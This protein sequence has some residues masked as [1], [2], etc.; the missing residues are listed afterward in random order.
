MVYSYNEKKCITA[1][2]IGNKAYNLF[3]LNDCTKSVPPWICL[4]NQFMDSLFKTEQGKSTY[5]YINMYMIN[6]I[7]LHDKLKVIRDKIKSLP[8]PENVYGLIIEKIKMAKLKPPYAVRSS[9][10]LEDNTKRSGAGIYDTILDVKHECL[11]DAILECI[12]SLFNEKAF[13]Y[14]GNRN[15]SMSE[16]KIAVIIQEMV[17][18]KKS[19]IIFTCNPVNSNY[20]EMIL[21]IGEG[22]GSGIVSG[23]K[24]VGTYLY[25]KVTKQMSIIEP[26]ET[27]LEHEEVEALKAFAYAIEKS[28]GIHQDIEWAID[29]DERVWLLQSRPVTTVYK[30]QSVLREPIIFLIQ[31][32]TDKNKEHL[33]HLK[34]R[35]NRWVK[36]KIPFSRA[37]ATANAPMSKWYFIKYNMHIITPKICD[38]ILNDIYS[39]YLFI[40][41]NDNVI[42]ITIRSVDLYKKLKELAE[43]F[44]GEDLTVAIKEAYPNDASILASLTD[45]GNIY[46]EYMPGALKWI[47][48]GVLQP[49]NMLISLEGNIL[50]QTEK[51]ND[52]YYKFDEATLDFTPCNESVRVALSKKQLKDIAYY[53]TEIIKQMGRKLVVEWWKWNDIIV[54]NDAS[55]LEHGDLVEEKDHS[56]Y[57]I[58]S[59]GEIDGVVLKI[60]DFCL[61]D[62]TYLSHGRGISVMDY[63]SEVNSLELLNS[64]RNQMQIYKDKGIKVI[65]YIDK[66]YLFFA[67]LADQADGFIFQ[68]ASLLCHFSIILREKQTPAISLKGRKWTGKSGDYFFVKGEI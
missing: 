51:E 16:L 64:I 67:P 25:N 56:D 62:V 27:E 15:W 63:E 8:I 38:S 35:Y 11:K 61:D 12:A 6:K 59:S 57:S 39:P 1:N 23:S 3:I 32:C 2:E 21:E 66:P 5:N 60:D 31:D 22:L 29:S 28:F 45:E 17:F 40:I 13:I 55:L 48:A 47:N 18:P 36:K 52:Y 14:A 43:I 19:G 4:G 46:L 34:S 50:R 41:A 37:C 9:A 26:G 68:E 58:I 7:K 30:K 54:A 49:S 42:D 44:G 65:L 33:G 10:I 24:P 53:T 20:A